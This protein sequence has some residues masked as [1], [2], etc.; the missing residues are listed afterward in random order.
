MNGT[1]RR[2]RLPGYLLIVLSSAA[3]AVE[4]SVCSLALTSGVSAPE[5]TAFA[6]AVNALLCVCL[7][8]LQGSPLKIDR[9]A[10]LKL[11]LFGFIGNGIC[12][13]C[14]SYAYTLLPVGCVTVLHFTYPTL[15]CVTM[16]AAFKSRVTGAK[17]G[18]VLCSLTGLVLIGFGELRGSTLGIALA[19]FS[20]VAYA[21]YIVALDRSSVEALPFAAETFYAVLGGVL[22]SGSYLVLTRSFSGA[23]HGTAL[24]QLLLCGALLFCG[25]IGFVGGVNIIGASAASFFS[26]LEPVGSLIFS[27]ILC[28]DVLSFRTLLGCGIS[29]CAMLLIT[30]DGRGADNAADGA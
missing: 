18:A 6:G 27:A 5:A 20:A 24:W 8:L 17:I 16:I 22:F 15:V 25:C 14:L 28:G 12:N 2:S 9:R 23:V 10:A 30:L 13:I 29:L 19:L 21:V 26:L 3:Y 4:P 7:A 1:A 11:V